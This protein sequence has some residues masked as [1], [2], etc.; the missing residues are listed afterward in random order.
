MPENFLSEP[1][2]APPASPVSLVTGGCGFIGQH[3]VRLLADRNHQVRVL[4]LTGSSRLDPRAKLFRGSILDPALLHQATAGAD[5]VFHL[6]A[7]PELW[8]PDKSTFAQ[9][10]HEGTVAVLAE[11]GRCG[12]R[13]IVHCS[14]ESILKGTRES[15]RTPANESVVRTADDMP[16][17]YCRSKFLAEC[18]AAE[19]AARGLPVVIVNPTLPIGPGDLRLTPPTRMILD[20]VNGAIPAYLEFAMNMVDVRDAALG[21]LLAAE[22][23]RVGER[24]ILGGEN[25]RLSEVLACL[26]ELT[27]LPMPRARIPHGLALTAAAV[28]EFVADHFTHRPPKASL[29]GV[30][31]AGTAMTFD[32][33][34]AERELG[35]KPRPVR[36]A[37]Q[38]AVNWLQAEGRI[39]RSLPA[40]PSRSWVSVSAA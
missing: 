7:N 39:E 12:V 20:F 24:Y 14:T 15:G 16:G 9:V 3:L 17:P 31:L 28:S 13:R 40:A 38:D 5:F 11:A 22:H 32:C 21:H 4:D 23:G 6:A 30:R 33:A 19:A 2:S 27:G 36:R 18:A 10:N 35:L 37:L 25:L 29:T 34:R 1:S 8:A 26:E